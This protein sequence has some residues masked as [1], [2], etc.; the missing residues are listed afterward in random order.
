MKTLLG[1]L[2]VVLAAAC[3]STS[4][5]STQGGDPNV[6]EIDELARVR[7]ATAYDIV[8]QLRPRFLQ[9]RGQVSI[10]NPDA[11]YAMVRL[12]AAPMGTLA[13]LRNIP[14]EIVQRI[15]F[16]SAADATT[17][18]G[19]GHSGGVILVTTRR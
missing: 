1:I 2:V 10:A 7:V 15:E 8:Q 11:G 5:R 3:G 9:R 16:I 17:R 6:I 19:T 13:Q 18:W 12:D 14:A 4:G